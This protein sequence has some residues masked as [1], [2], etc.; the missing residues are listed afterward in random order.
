MKET[1]SALQEELAAFPWREEG[2]QNIK[3][4][5]TRRPMYYRPDLS[6]HSKH[7]AWL[8]AAALPAALP[9]LGAFDAK[10]MCAVALVHDDAEIVTGDYEAG[11][12]AN[13]AHEQLAAID[14]H[15][16]K[17]I[18]ELAARFPKTVGGYTYEE[19]LFDIL[20]LESK[21]AQFAKYLDRFDGFG[22]GIHEI[23]AGNPQ[24]TEKIVTEY[25]P[26]PHF[27]D[28]NVD[29]RARMMEKHSALAGLKDTSLF[30]S[31]PPFPDWKEVVQKGSFH[32]R[33]RLAETTEFAQYDIWKKTILD[34]GDEK[35]IKHLYLQQESI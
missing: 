21:E 10:K 23:Y 20:D 19:L 28:L 34:S 13:M 17:A 15:E 11:N 9:L 22:E 16:R 8:A 30:F 3:R 5:K 35:E 18:H 25:G 33:E 4:W 32:T 6:T 12:K 24:F 7:V 27:Y 29:L 1:I 2:L 31:F 14:K 26:M